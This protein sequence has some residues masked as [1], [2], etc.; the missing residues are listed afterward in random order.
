MTVN[1]SEAGALIVGRN[2]TFSCSVQGGEKLAG[3][4]VFV[5]MNSTGN[6]IATVDA[7][8][9]QS[10]R[11]SDAGQYTCL[12]TIAGSPYLDANVTLSVNKSTAISIK[13]K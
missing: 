5:W 9:F 2:Y 7:L 3:K 8:H 12:S 11:L 1:I 6:V 13:S 4:T 10:L